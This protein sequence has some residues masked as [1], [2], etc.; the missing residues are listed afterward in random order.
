MAPKKALTDACK[1]RMH[2]IDAVTKNTVA[3]QNMFNCLDVP[4]ACRLEYVAIRKLTLCVV[5]VFYM[6]LHSMLRGTL[7]PLSDKITTM[8]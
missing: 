1:L 2:A 5:V 8:T 3:I 4:V 7:A 6:K